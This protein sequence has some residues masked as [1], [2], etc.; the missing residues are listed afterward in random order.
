MVLLVG[1]TEFTVLFN[2]QSGE[3]TSALAA[4]DGAR[5]WHSMRV[6]GA[7]LAVAVPVY[8]FYYYVRDRLGMAWRRWLTFDFLRSYFRHRAFYRLTSDQLIDNPD[9]RIA[10]DVGA[11]T[12]KS[13]KFLVE[14]VGA[15]RAAGGL[16]RHPLVHLQDPGVVLVLY[17]VLGTLITFRR[18][19]QTADWFE[20]SAAAQGGRLSFRG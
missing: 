9:Q 14:I 17:A 1:R 4:R 11:F 3:F 18:I 19:R 16:Q 6:F 7:A 20:L 10:E 15:V 5:F 13:L 2:E 12:Q 8:A